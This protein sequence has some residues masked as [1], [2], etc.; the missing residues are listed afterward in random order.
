M[1]VS[2]GKENWIRLGRAG[3]KETA[4]LGGSSGE[5]RENLFCVTV[6]DQVLSRGGSW[7]CFSTL[8]KVVLDNLLEGL[9]VWSFQA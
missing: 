6:T 3:R 9:C 4:S 8:L 5:F 7:H 1:E 2:L